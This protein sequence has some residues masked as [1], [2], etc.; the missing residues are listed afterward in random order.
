M[1]VNPGIVRASYMVVTIFHVKDPSSYICMEG[2][3]ASKV[4]GFSRFLGSNAQ[5]QEKQGEKQTDL[6]SGFHIHP[7]LLSLSRKTLALGLRDI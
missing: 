1:H 7:G 6:D 3:S 5:T 4:H 2:L